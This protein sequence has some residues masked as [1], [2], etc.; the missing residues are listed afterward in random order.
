MLLISGRKFS[1]AVSAV[2]IDCSQNMPCVALNILKINWWFKA[3][4]VLTKFRCLISIRWSLKLTARPWTQ[5]GPQQGTFIWPSFFRELSVSGRFKYQWC[6]MRFGYYYTLNF[7]QKQFLGHKGIDVPMWLQKKDFY[8]S[9][10][11]HHPN[12]SKIRC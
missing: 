11:T 2:S 8:W 3:I 9:V 12:G 7:V 10:P 5:A 6:S 1:G 4:Q